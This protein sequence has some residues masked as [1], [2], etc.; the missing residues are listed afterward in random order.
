MLKLPIFKLWL[1]SVIYIP[2]LILA[3]GFVFPNSHFPTWFE[4][5][6]KSTAVLA[7]LII[8]LVPL[9]HMLTPRKRLQVLKISAY[10]MVVGYALLGGQLLYIKLKTCDRNIIPHDDRW[11]CN[12]SG[13]GVIVYFIAIPILA[14]II[15]I[16]YVGLERL[17]RRGKPKD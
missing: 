16:S 2:A 1:A 9:L 5:V 3:L 6:L 14:A 11:H 4:L 17:M 8:V 7:F 13:K 12:V 15:G 10:S